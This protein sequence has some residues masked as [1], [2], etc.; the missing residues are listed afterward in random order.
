M[1]ER[2]V[3]LSYSPKQR[4]FHVQED[5][6]RPINEDWLWLAR[7]KEN[8]VLRFTGHS[9]SQKIFD[10]T[11]PF[12][13]EFYED[14]QDRCQRQLGKD[15]YSN[16]NRST[17]GKQTWVYLMK[18][19]RSG[20][21]KIGESINPRY[22]ESTLQSEQPLIELIEAWEGTWDD[23][24]D[25]HRA[26]AEKRIRGEWFSLDEGDI[27]AIRGDFYS[28][29]RYSTGIAELYVDLVDLDAAE[30]AGLIG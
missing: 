23:E 13:R 8:R 3:Y 21:V 10:M 16:W 2:M 25:L 27:E 5:S 4:C 29:K 12:A 17:K 9:A 11:P 18:D 14:F 24:Q 28:R 26:Y 30:A 6:T 7:D 19:L 15:H 1:S 22:R 20:Y